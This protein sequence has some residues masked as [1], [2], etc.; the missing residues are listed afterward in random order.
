MDIT[1]LLRRTV[2]TRPTDIGTVFCRRQRTWSEFLGRV[3]KLAGAFRSSG[4]GDGGRIATLMQNS[5]R[6]F[7]ILFATAWAGASAVPL[8][9][10]WRANE[11]AEAIDDAAVRILIVDDANL[12][13]AHEL[14]AGAPDDLRVIYAGERDAPLPYPFYEALIED[15]APSRCHEQ[16]GD[17]V[18]AIFYT[19]GT[20]GRSKGVMVSHGNIISSTLASVAENMFA[21][22][23]VYLNCMPTFHLSSAWPVVAAVMTGAK[24]IVQ[25]TV[26]PGNM[27]EAID[28]E[29]ITETFLVPTTIQM[30]IEHPSFPSCNTR[31]L[32]RVIYGAS[33]I[34]ETLLDRALAAF[35]QTEFIHVYGMTELSPLAT[36]LPSVNLLEEGRA[37]G[38]HRS[39]GRAIYG[40]EIEIV[41]SEGNPVPRGTVGEI[42]VRG[43]NVMLGYW[44]RPAET[45]SALRDGRLYTGDGAYM[46]EDGFVYIV[47]RVKDMIISGGEN[48]YSAEVE[49]VISQHPA[50][51]QCAVIGIPD[52]KWGEQVHAV[53]IPDGNSPVDAEDIIGFCRER[54]AGYKCPRGVSF[55][56]EPLPLSPVGKILKHELRKLYAQ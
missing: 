14:A 27:L 51:Q 50:V 24:S 13:T 54:M 15:A 16:G 55:R 26:E 3:Q 5:D 9:I 21:E 43:D 33:P 20:T 1:S 52:A 29:H 31:S 38:R 35:P 32:R 49:N 8:N 39:A 7:E 48:I 12:E 6:Y 42:T 25:A 41:D 4:I 28:R 22:D 23:T 47:D 56:T 10:R 19:G 34:T 17:A 2:Q 37:K 18:F 11:L 30:L 40:V 44:N 46:D 53:V 36:A 45:A